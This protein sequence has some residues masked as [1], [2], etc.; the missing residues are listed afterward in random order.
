MIYVFCP[1]KALL[2]G[3]WSFSSVWRP[4]V[5]QSSFLPL[6]QREA[7]IQT[8]M[9]LDFVIWRWTVFLLCC[10]ITQIFGD[11]EIRDE[12]GDTLEIDHSWKEWQAI[13]MKSNLIAI[14]RHSSCLILCYSF[15]P[16]TVCLDWTTRLPRFRTKSESSPVHSESERWSSFERSWSGL[17]K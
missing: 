10:L 11:S 17:V 4:L 9:L 8:C 6:S 2:S 5:V 1:N 16:D 7:S 15:I 14:V 12:K 13:V 3:Q